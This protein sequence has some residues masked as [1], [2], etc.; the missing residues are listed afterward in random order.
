MATDCGVSARLLRTWV[1]ARV[2]DRG[3][4]GLESR[5]ELEGQRG[6]ENLAVEIHSVCRDTVLH[7]LE[8]EEDYT[9]SKGAG[10]GGT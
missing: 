4:A 6:T 7:E 8:L 9:K 1:R 10:R 5:R 2:R 3:E